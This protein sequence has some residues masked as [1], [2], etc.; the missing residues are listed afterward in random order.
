MLKLKNST[1]ALDERHRR[2]G[3]M[4]AKAY[5]KTRQKYGVIKQVH[6]KLYAA[7]VLLDTG[8]VASADDWIPI[9][10]PWQEL[11][12]NFGPLRKNLRVVVEYEGDQENHATARVIGLEGEPIAQQQER[13]DVD[14]ALYEIFTPGI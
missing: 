11:V 7:K 14:L 2:Q 5:F 1:N 13:A 4:D 3:Q 8:G 6:E 9:T 10:N 12:H